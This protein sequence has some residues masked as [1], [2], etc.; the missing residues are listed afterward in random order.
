MGE[1]RACVRTAELEQHVTGILNHAGLSAGDAQISA[2]VLMCGDRRGVQ[3]H[4]VARLKRY[5]DDIK[6]GTIKPGAQMIVAHETPVSLVID[7]NAGMGQVI[8]HHAMNRCIEKA[9]QSFMCFA[10]VRNS[11]HFGIAGHYVLMA[12]KQK[13]IGICMTN[14]APLLVPTFGKDAVLGTNPLAV[15]VPAGEEDAFVLDMAAS[16]V[17]RGKLEV[18]AREERKM[19]ETWATDADGLATDDPQ[20]VLDNLTARKG[21]GLSPVGGAGVENGGHKGYGLAAMIDIFCGVFSGGAVGS[22]VYGKKGQP[23]EV[24]HFFGAIHPDAFIGLT[25]IQGRM[26]YFIRMLRHS[27]LARNQVRIYVAG[28][29]EAEFARKSKETLTLQAKVFKTLN[30]LGL[31]YGLELKEASCAKCE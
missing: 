30:E 6:G 5:V 19:P 9:K 11:N 22:D 20:L 14:S 12:L 18:Y 26:D 28:E 25:G 15:G 3:S 31:E 23:P 8:A 17:P 16:T 1:A 2:N 21:G 7:G 10:A 29:I 27:A 13:M 4:G 24:A